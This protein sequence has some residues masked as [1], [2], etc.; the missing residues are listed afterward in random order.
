MQSKLAQQINNQQ[1]PTKRRAESGS[2]GG[3]TRTALAEATKKLQQEI[4][5]KNQKASRKKT[6]KSNHK[7]C[8][9]RMK[10]F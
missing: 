5:E 8:S 9:E 3:E 1:S 4:Q 6:S 2:S 7:G 10:R